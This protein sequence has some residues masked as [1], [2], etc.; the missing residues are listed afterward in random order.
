[1]LFSSQIANSIKSDP[2]AG[3]TFVGV[4]PCDLL[5]ENIDFP[6]SMVA[7]T[8]PAAKPG[9][10]WVALLFDKN[11]NG[12]Y[13]DSYGFA[14]ITVPI[15]NYFTF[16]HMAKSPCNRIPIVNDKHLQGT[17]SSVCGQYCIAYLARRAR[18]ESRESIVESYTGKQPGEFDNQ[19]EQVVNKTYN[20]TPVPVLRRKKK[21]RS[22]GFQF[23]G[24][25][26]VD[27]IAQEDITCIVEQC[28]CSQ[29]SCFKRDQCHSVSH[30][31]G[32]EK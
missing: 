28:C 29:S 4:F 9:S 17:E 32:T 11:G 1:M 18:G 30:T 23:G 14:P 19:V 27:E 10:H 15:F 6:C 5:P 8:D 24:S 26:D 16:Q 21:K 22:V 2:Y 13:F 25:S 7:N 31:H 12:E 20:I 3:S